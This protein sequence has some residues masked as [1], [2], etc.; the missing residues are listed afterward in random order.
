MIG[1]IRHVNPFFLITLF[2][3]I[4]VGC[5]YLKSTGIHDPAVMFQTLFGGRALHTF[6]LQGLFVMTAVLLQFALV[7]Y[8]VFSIDNSDY[9]FV[10]YGNRT[11][12][13]KSLIT[14]A[15]ILTA[16]FVVLVY[17]IGLLFCL[18]ATDFK[19]S[20]ALN[21]HTAVVLARVYLFCALAGLAQIYLLLKYT[22]AS[23]FAIVSGIAIFLVLT[24]RYQDMFVSILP[25]SRSPWM[26]W[27]DVLITIV[28]AIVLVILIQRRSLNRELSDH[29][30]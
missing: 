28:L 3:G 19:I 4:A 16:A 30:N 14:G 15:L 1:A 24:S 12:W 22:K 29:E 27:L 13:F 10:R 9:L 7:D 6:L 23:V 2:G 20:Q 25:R 18:A 21:M 17:A 5:L 8:L 26:T 11:L